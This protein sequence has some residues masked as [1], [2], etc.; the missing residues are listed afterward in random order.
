MIERCVH[1]RPP[2]RNRVVTSY[3]LKSPAD[4]TDGAPLLAWRQKISE[5]G[6]EARMVDPII[7]DLSLAFVGVNLRMYVEDFFESKALRHREG[8]KILR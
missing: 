4:G 5:G 3:D 6:A 7:D 1:G 8:F 2:S